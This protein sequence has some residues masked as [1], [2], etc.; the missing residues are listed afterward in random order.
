[1]DMLYRILALAMLLGTLL[2][3]G[4]PKGD[5]GAVTQ[6]DAAGDTATDD[7]SGAEAEGGV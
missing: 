7:A 5:E 2:L 6:P 4:C 3:A 1:M